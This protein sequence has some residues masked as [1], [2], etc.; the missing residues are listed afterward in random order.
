MVRQ[1]GV[2]TE[3]E[4]KHF[5]AAGYSKQQLLKIVLGIFQKVMSNY[6]NHLAKTPVDEPFK[7][8]I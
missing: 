5:F 3:E 2:L 4:I 7:K 6:T 1:R 8:Y